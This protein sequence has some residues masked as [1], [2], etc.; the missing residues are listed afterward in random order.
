[1][2]GDLVY[3][4]SFQPTGESS[5]GVFP[6]SQT[7]YIN[8]VTITK[9]NQTYFS[10]NWRSELNYLQ[11]STDQSTEKMV[12]V[13]QMSSG[14]IKE[15]PLVACRDTTWICRRLIQQLQSLKTFFLLKF[16]FYNGFMSLPGQFYEGRHNSHPQQLKK[17][18]NFKNKARKHY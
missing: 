12:Q 7:M 13:Q 14:Q 10:H 11:S 9:H 4:S 3:T 16:F 18:S 2:D 1:M 5:D 6:V 17:R 8:Y 15:I